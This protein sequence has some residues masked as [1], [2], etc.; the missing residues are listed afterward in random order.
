MV[1]CLQFV[2]VVSA[3]YYQS[4]FKGNFR[5]KIITALMQQQART[6]QMLKDKLNFQQGWNEYMQNGLNSKESENKNK[7][8]Q[9]GFN[10]A[11]IRSSRK[12]V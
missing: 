5:M 2:Q 11:Q 8:F 12:A 10:F 9:A 7:L 4:F 1:V 3:L 6:I